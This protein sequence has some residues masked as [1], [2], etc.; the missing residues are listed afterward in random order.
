MF[1]KKQFQLMRKNSVFVN[2]ARGLIISLNQYAS[3]VFCIMHQNVW[4][5]YSSIAG[6]RKDKRYDVED[7]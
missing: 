2:I 6:D 1:G 7:T 4:G 3:Q 5:I